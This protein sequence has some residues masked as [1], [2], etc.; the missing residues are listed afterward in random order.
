MSKSNI[1]YKLN[2]NDLVYLIFIASVPLFL[3]NLIGLILM[4]IIHGKSI[5]GS[6][7]IVTFISMVFGLILFPYYFIK[8]K[9]GA[10]Y[11]DIGI[12]NVTGIEIAI[13]SVSLFLMYSYIL[14]KDINNSIYIISIQTII[15]AISEEVWAR[16]VLCYVLSKI[17]DKKWIILI[18]SSIIF[19]FLTHMNRPILDNLIYRLPGSII[20]GI[21]YLKTK[22]LRYSI[23]IHYLYN[24]ITYF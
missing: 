18:I 2:I 4:V 6:D 24:M 9:Y 21:T 1:K 15:V 8:S 20:M 3:T 12:R 22:N 10:S 14:N 7:I 23:L 11:K 19:A 16:G 13:F 5:Y 17:T